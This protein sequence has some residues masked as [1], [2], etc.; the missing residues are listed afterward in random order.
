MSQQA[1]RKEQKG[2]AHKKRP[3]NKGKQNG[4]TSASVRRQMYTTPHARQEI[5]GQVQDDKLTFLNKIKDADNR[6]YIMRHKAR[7]RDFLV[8]IVS[9]DDKYRLQNNSNDYVLIQKLLRK[10]NKKIAWEAVKEQAKVDC[11]VYCSGAVPNDFAVRTMEVRLQTMEQLKYA[12]DNNKIDD[13]SYQRIWKKY[14]SDI[15]SKDAM[16]NSTEIGMLRAQA[17]GHIYNDNSRL[18]LIYKQARKNK[19]GKKY[20]PEDYDLFGYNGRGEPLC[21]AWHVVET[22]NNFQHTLPQVQKKLSEMGI[23]PEDVYKFNHYDFADVIAKSGGLAQVNDAPYR[24]FCKKFGKM[25]QVGTGIF[26]EAKK[27]KIW[28]DNFATNVELNMNDD[29]KYEIYRNFERNSRRAAEKIKNDFVKGG[30]SEDYF[31]AWMNNMAKNGEYTPQ[32]VEW[33]KKD[34]AIPYKIDIHHNRRLS[35]GG[36]GLNNLSNFSLIVMFNSFDF[37]VH[38]F[39]HQGESKNFILEKYLTQ[40]VNDIDVGIIYQSSNHFNVRSDSFCDCCDKCDVCKRLKI[41]EKALQKSAELKNRVKSH[42]DKNNG[43]SSQMLQKGIGG[44]A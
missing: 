28:E 42:I 22:S 1:V 7:C 8:D 20:K 39:K 37:D 36:E 27:R 5:Y 23:N 38:G 34:G 29:E 40:N 16:A 12:C 2:I 15:V 9:S 18:S 11:K 19:K 13:V 44:Y 25:L 24:E 6:L 35:S 21:G 14:F 31:V 3:W 26:N 10:Y 4:Q 30:I 32:S 17:A 43:Q 41:N 33:K